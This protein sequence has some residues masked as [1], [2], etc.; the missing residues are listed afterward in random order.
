MAIDNNTNIIG[1]DLWEEDLR[2]GNS[3]WAE[4]GS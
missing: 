3:A 1:D 2:R 4:K